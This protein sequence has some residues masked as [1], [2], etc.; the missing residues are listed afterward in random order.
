[1][2]KS[3]MLSRKIAIDKELNELS[4]KSQLIY[5]WCI[6][7]LDDY[8]LLT[9]NTGDIKYLIFPRN[10]NIEERDIDMFLAEARPNLIEILNDC[11]HF[12]GFQ[13]HNQLTEYKKSFSQFEENIFNKGKS[14]N[15]PE[16][17]RIPQNNSPKVK[18]SKVK[19]SKVN[20][21]NIDIDLSRLLSDKIKENLTS[22]KEP[23]IT[24]WARDIEKMRR[25]DK[26]T[27][28]QI[29]F[30]IEWCQKNKF[31][32]A[33]ILSTK[34]LREKFDTLVAQIKRDINNNKIRS[35]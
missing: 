32:Q 16:F 23:N 13:N 9:N 3:R 24:S 17:P 11:I 4:L 8:G 6:P 34:K 14:K 5:T 26:R 27:P 35:L 20:I 2:A 33:N 12:N 31:W 19:E 1:M 21:Y 10:T 15:S 22:F 18:E 29:K 28:E 30:V 25:I 7:F